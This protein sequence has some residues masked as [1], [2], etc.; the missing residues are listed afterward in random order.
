MAGEMDAFCCET[1]ESSG[2]DD[3]VS[4]LAFRKLPRVPSEEIMSNE[5]RI[6]VHSAALNF[7]ELLSFLGKYQVPIEP[8]FA[9]GSEGSGV[10]VELG[11][12]VREGLKVGQRVCWIGG[13]RGSL[14]DECI[15][16]DLFVLP[17]PDRWTFDQAAGFAMGYCTSYHALIQRG[18][19]RKGE[20][21]LVTGAAGG[22]G[23]SAIQIAKAFGAGQIIAVVSTKEKADAALAAGATH[24]VN[25]AEQDL[26]EQV[27]ELTGGDG[28][29]V[30]YEVVGGDVFQKVSRCMAGGGR[31]LVVGF[32]SGEIPKLAANLPLVK[33][34]SVVG[35]R[36]GYEMF[37]DE[38]VSQE[39]RSFMSDFDRI[40]EL[41]PVVSI[42]YP[43]ERAR[44]AFEQLA[45]RFVSLPRAVILLL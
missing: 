33:G 10:I 22:M 19:L 41:I 18:N 4:K 25:L 15:I 35:V 13:D 30:A 45:Q 32:T 17:I 31:L 2:F 12:D 8:P 44:D 38:A 14:A 34:Y 6:Q 36:S 39:L 28:V 1:L 21:V 20:S 37:A 24:A 7:F 23:L 5:V 43:R 40:D 29:D 3:A 16:A 27:R 42:I 26:R 11:S 9:A